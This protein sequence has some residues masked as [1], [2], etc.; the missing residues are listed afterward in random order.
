MANPDRVRVTG[1]LT[2]FVG[3]FAAELARQGYRPDAA[4]SQLQLMAH[5]SRWLATQGWDAAMLTAP[6]MAEFLAARRAAGYRLWLSPKALAPLVGY[7]HGFGAIPSP[8]EAAATPVEALL[9]RYRR[10]PAG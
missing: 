3:G 7:L 6:V 1:P 9:A 10:L 5:L 2:P 4:A 8:P